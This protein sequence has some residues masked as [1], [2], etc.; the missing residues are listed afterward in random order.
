MKPITDSDILQFVGLKTLEPMEQEL[1]QRISTENFEKIR[2]MLKNI[3]KV[4]VQIKTYEK[5]GKRKKYSIHLQARA[6]GGPLD[7]D[8]AQD[9]DLA[10]AIHKGFADLKGLIE[11][12]MHLEGLKGMKK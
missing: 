11:H 3:T 1:V 10:R 4:K 12:R 7:V 2:R 9:F 6:P 8:R 5:Q